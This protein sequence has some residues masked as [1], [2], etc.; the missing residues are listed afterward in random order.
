MN[1]VNLTGRLTKDPELMYANRA[2]SDEQTAICKFILAVDR[3]KYKREG[4]DQT[5][6][7]IPCVAF[8]KTAEFIAKYFQQGSRINLSGRIQTG[9]YTNKDGVKVYT[10]EIIILE[11]EFGGDRHETQAVQQETQPQQNQVQQSQTQQA[12]PQQSQKPRGGI[13]I[14][15]PNKG[16]APN[17]NADEIEE[18][19]DVLPFH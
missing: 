18:E 3:G 15:V 17:I 14:P 6:D 16:I 5:A 11:V 19:D 4:A 2:S 12:Q 7:F 10:F 9:S 13:S 8:G 1:S